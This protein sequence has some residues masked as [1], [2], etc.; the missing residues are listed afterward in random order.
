[1]SRK[2][3]WLSVVG[4]F[5]AL[6]LAVSVL[7]PAFSAPSSG[8]R[9]FHLCDQNNGGRQH[10][11]NVGSRRFSPGDEDMTV[12]PVYDRGSGKRAGKEIALFTV[13]DLEPPRDATFR[14]SATFV[15]A[16][17]KVEAVAAG[18]FSSLQKNGLGIVITGG[19]N[20]FSGA[21]GSGVATSGM[22]AGKHGTHITL[23]VSG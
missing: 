2:L 7:V 16:G 18:K 12:G 22:C 5:A 11:V 6:A 3:A 17:G 4:G 9:V 15:L 23:N 20:N 19:T 8:T 10:H 1:M 21:S 13:L 14:I